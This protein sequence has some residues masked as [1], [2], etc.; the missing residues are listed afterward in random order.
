M[1]EEQIS[2]RSLLA[3]LGGAGAA[4]LSRQGRAVAAALGAEGQG[5]ERSEARALRAATERVEADASLASATGPL[6]LAKPVLDAGPGQPPIIARRA[7]AGHDSPPARAP[8]YGTVEL[9]FVHHTDSPNGYSPAEVPALIRSIYL[10][11]RFSN[12]WNDIGYNFV[13]DR[14]GRIFE[15]RAG[16]I[17][18]PVVGAQAGGYNG[19]STGIALLGDYEAIRLSSAARQSLQ[20]LIA[21]KLSLH[22]APVAGEIT[23]HCEPGGAVY[24]RFPANA[25]VRL[26]R[27]SGHRQADATSCPGEALFRQLPEIR[28]LAAKLA[29]E[30]AL[31]TLAVQAERPAS[32]AGAAAERTLGGTL[33]LLD[34]RPIAAA[35]I[36]IQVREDMQHGERVSER[37]I[38]TATT[39]AEGAF[40]ATVAV[41]PDPPRERVRG[42]DPQ[43]QG[44]EPPR[45]QIALRALSAG[46]TGAPAAVSA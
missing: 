37:T 42:K 45:P 43:K 26:S 11:H 41:E 10:Y 4:V 28:R 40:A 29:G 33:A 27:V 35:A 3:L 13:I 14:F 1:D 8:E 39:D 16:G 30:P 15:A 31:L 12:G 20:K 9:A 18:E 19:F 7:W 6:P 44:H 23:V 46:A 25:A 17:D 5:G 21:W 2:R 22:G 32:E 34:G 24:S 38:A 36:E